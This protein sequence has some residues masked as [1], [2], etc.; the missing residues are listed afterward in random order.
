MADN[1]QMQGLE[2][3]IVGDGKKVS[4]GL[5]AL[6]NSLK[7]VKAAT[8]GGI[9]LQKIASELKEFQKA[10][11]GLQLGETAKSIRSIANAI[12]KIGKIEFNANGIQNASAS[13]KGIADLD[14]GNLK[15]A[16]A[17]VSEIAKSSGISKVVS[18]D[19]RSPISSK[20]TSDI[21]EVRVSDVTQEISK[22]LEVID[23]LEEKIQ[24]VTNSTSGI[25]GNLDA[26]SV[27][28]KSKLE[29]L[30]NQVDALKQKF[31]EKFGAEGFGDE[32]IA[33]MALRIKGLEERYEKLSEAARKASDSARDIGDTGGAQVFQGMNADAITAMSNVDLLK[34]KIQLLKDKLN[35]GIQSG[36]LDSGKIADSAM[37][38]Q[39][40]Q[41]QL[42]NIGKESGGALVLSKISSAFRGLASAAA[43]AVP[44]VARLAKKIGSNLVSTTA[45]AASSAVRFSRNI[46]SIP[47]RK[48]G[49]NISS[50]VKAFNKF[51]SS[52][53]RIAVYR[54]IRRAIQMI[55]QAFK[56][57]TNNIYEYS[58]AMGT[59]FK[60]S[61][62]SIATSG[63]YVKN[64]FGE[65]A[66][67][68]LNILAP[69]L[70][71][72]ADKVATVVNLLAQLMALLGGKSTYTKAVKGATEY[73]KAA[74]GAAKATKDFMLGLDELNVFNPDTGGGGGGAAA[75]FSDMFEEAEIDTG[76][77]D[78]VQRLKDAF[79]AGD[80][81]GLGAL[82]GDKF[83]ELFDMIPWDAIGEKAG[84][85]LNAVITTLS[86]ILEHVNFENVGT[87]FSTFFNSLIDNID[88][89]TWGKLFVQKLE[90][91]PD[92]LIGFIDGLYPSLVGKKIG[93]FF[94]G[95]IDEAQSW[96]SEKPWHE[97]GN[98]IGT[99]IDEVFTNLYEVLSTHSFG[100][101][102][103]SLAELLN[104]AL[105]KANLSTVAATLVKVLTIVPDEII[106]FFKKLNPEL[107]GNSIADF[108]KGGVDEVVKWINSH[109]EDFTIIAQNVSK[110]INTA[111]SSISNWLDNK[112]F[113]GIGEKV[114]G[115]VNSAVTGINWM[116]I[117]ETAGKL[118][119]NALGELRKAIDKIDWKAM[120]LKFATSLNKFIQ[121]IDWA[122]AGQ[123]FSNAFHGVL[124]FLRE[125]VVDFD[126]AGLGRAIGEF[127]VNIDWGQLFLDLVEIGG[128]IIGGLLEGILNVFGTIGAWIK[129]HVFDPFVNAIK[130]LFGIHSPS[131]VMAEIGGLLIEGLFNRISETWHT[132]A[133]F[134]SG[135]FGNLI[136]SIKDWWTD[137]KRDTKE[138]WEKIKDDLSKNWDNIKKDAKDK[139]EDARDKITAVWEKVET[140]TNT[141]WEGL[142]K[143]LKDSWKSLKDDS[144]EKFEWI[145]D[146]ITGVWRDTETDTGTKW[147][148][149][150]SSL[151]LQ[152]EQLKKDA[153]TNFKGIKEKI[154]GWWDSTD[155]DAVDK[156]EKIKKNIVKIF[157]T[158]KQGLSD[159]WDELKRWWEGLELPSFKIKL[160]HFSLSG[161]FSLDPPSI[162]KILVDWY[163]SGGFP[164]TGQLFIAREAGPE[165]VGRMNNRTA[166]ANNGQIIDGIAAG[167]EDANI[168]V[169]AAIYQLIGVAEEIAAK[170]NS[171]YIGD[172][173][174]GRANDRYT[175]NRGVRVNNGA[176]AN[177]Y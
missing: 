104:G 108:I 170:D 40:L 78:F 41:A 56:E 48:F 166:V 2:F 90:I 46:I 64:L 101:L 126:W 70:D 160:P 49:Q 9:G 80:W 119:S 100:L 55:S 140:K 139:F 93:D 60:K 152:W 111:F 125:A 35:E 115:F 33:S 114:G 157:G 83:N 159:K 147:N 28:A 136:K 3:E 172:N 17:S 65:L 14:F 24:E 145:Q 129:E 62:D 82:I 97:I 131:T 84:K 1:V 128:Y 67:P 47:F 141:V 51:T 105:E 86:S 122:N 59:D 88:F 146:K 165:L 31:S 130:G 149:I 42:D 154:S 21:P 132:I 106:S 127:I 25:F 7:K 72:L 137:V 148:S 171:V 16:A 153:N 85:G 50:T 123:T 69:A 150:V 53:G 58:R 66:A 94:N 162:P 167:V 89:D 107:V 135:A 98:K 175:S 169:I 110:A 23:D 155:T 118:F 13:L 174:I 168:G 73:S 79:N 92:I 11:S 74:G 164:D 121:N 177:A 38:I 156:W 158:V 54:L 133:D 63:L 20:V 43:K 32:Q 81:E 36:S 116:K 138:K 4:S 45:Q 18:S 39:K 6:A 120:G 52:I 8:S 77:G 109:G 26:D 30:G 142:G 22:T 29:L 27:L 134:F 173:E 5:D 103:E 151:G 99:L 15:D 176:F 112:P 76:L 161:K 102:G 96:L 61:M 87:G 75:D 57:G 163:A 124:Q 144:K 19:G 44:A 68:I 91:I 113:S 37:Q 117:G 34:A 95:A 10:V 143:S 71:I 12:G